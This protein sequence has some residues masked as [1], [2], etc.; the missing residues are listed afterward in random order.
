MSSLRFSDFF[1][2]SIAL[3]EAAAI[4]GFA[5][6]VKIKHLKSYTQ[7]IYGEVL[8]LADYYLR[9]FK[10]GKLNEYYLTAEVRGLQTG[11]LYLLVKDVKYE[12]IRNLETLLSNEEVEVLF[13]DN[14]Y[15]KKNL[16]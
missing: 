15:W 16:R 8:V 4:L 3:I 12:N 9:H 7:Q 2:T 10:N 11:D 1:A 14:T 6:E 13:E 5:E